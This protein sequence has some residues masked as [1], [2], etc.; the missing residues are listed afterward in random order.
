VT[1]SLRSWQAL[2]AAAAGRRVA[3]P[4][5]AAAR[6]RIGMARQ[7]D[8][9]FETDQ[10]VEQLRLLIEARPLRPYGALAVAQLR[11]GQGLDRLG[12]RAEAVAAYR[13]ALG[14]VT[15]KDPLKIADQARAGIRTAPNGDGAVAYRLS[16]EGWRAFERRAFDQAGRLLAQSLTLRPDD[17]VARYRQARVMDARNSDT[18]ALGAYE[19][20][21]AARATTPPTFYAS[22][23]VDAARLHEQHGSAERA[24]ELYRIARDVFGADRSTKD[25]ADRAIA[26]LTTAAA[27][28]LR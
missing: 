7:L 13:A 1:A 10:A 16:L 12:A 26:R 3:D 22:A 2:A 6:A 9:L 24:L 25:A 8:R 17:Q 19:A 18:A 11:L 15:A 21:V 5:A 20:I 4:V 23:C 27:A 14:A 28:P